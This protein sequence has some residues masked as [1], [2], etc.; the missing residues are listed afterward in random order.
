[1]Q[2]GQELELV[3]I[4]V[5]RAPCDEDS[6]TTTPDSTSSSRDVSNA[7]SGDEGESS[8]SLSG[9]GALHPE[10]KNA[11]QLIPYFAWP[12]L[13]ASLASVSSAGV[14]FASLP[15][16]PTFTLAAWRL[17][18]TGFLLIPG[19]IYQYVNIPAGAT[20][21]LHLLPA[22]LLWSCPCGWLFCVSR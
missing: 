9:Q 8:V 17:Q 15:E 3:A 18:T 19:A 11:T 4:E 16:V 22:T 20:A 10:S 6:I 21:A 7:V 14:V 2:R 12:L 1:M 13:L 5:L